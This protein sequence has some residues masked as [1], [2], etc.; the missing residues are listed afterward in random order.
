M[1][2]IHKVQLCVWASTQGHKVFMKERASCLYL[3]GI[4]DSKPKGM[5]WK[6][7][8]KLYHRCLWEQRWRERKKDRAGL[9][10]G[11][12]SFLIGTSGECSRVGADSE[13][14]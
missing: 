14:L 12:G 10:S 1:K 9:E 13:G 6:E 11:E 2:K 4:V 5:K 3:E 7:R 8:G